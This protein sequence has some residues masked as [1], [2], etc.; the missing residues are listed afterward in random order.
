MERALGRG[1]ECPGYALERPDVPGLAGV[2]E[3]GKKSLLTIHN[4]FVIVFI[5]QT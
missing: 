3:V 5:L 1:P 2:L 4:Y